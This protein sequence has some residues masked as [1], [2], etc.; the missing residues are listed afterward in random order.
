[1]IDSCFHM[2]MFSLPAPHV[3]KWRLSA[4]VPWDPKKTQY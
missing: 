4:V 3:E 2:F 1:L